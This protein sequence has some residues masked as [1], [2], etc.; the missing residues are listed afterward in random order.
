K[1]RIALLQN[2][3]ISTHPQV[4]TADGETSGQLHFTL[5][6]VNDNGMPI[7][8]ATVTIP[9]YGWSTNKFNGFIDP[10]KE[11]LAAFKTDHEG[12]ARVE[13]PE[14][15]A[16]AISIDII[17]AEATHPDYAK[18][19]ATLELTSVTKLVMQSGF[20]LAVM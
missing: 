13:T 11:K 7:K 17:T 15:L 2:D 10:P 1:K 5:Q 4:V 9:R 8:D 6:V 14:K 3:L 16:D 20:R 19:R 12:R 18:T